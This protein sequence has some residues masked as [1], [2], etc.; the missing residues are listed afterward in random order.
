[1][2]PP[3]IKLFGWQGERVLTGYK[4]VG[5]YEGGVSGA[6]DVK[7]R[8]YTGTLGMVVAK[9]EKKNES[10]GTAERRFI[11]SN[12]HVLAN[13]NDAA[14]G[15]P[16]IHPGRYYEDRKKQSTIGKLYGFAEITH[17]C[18]KRHHPEK[19]YV[20]AA[21]AEITSE[22]MLQEI[23]AI[24]KP[25]G[26]MRKDKVAKALQGAPY[27]RLEVQ[28]YGA[29]TGRTYG[30]LA[31]MGWDGWVRYELDAGKRKFAWFED[32]MLIRPKAKDDP[33]GFC[34]PGDSGAIVMDMQNRI[35]GLLF[36]SNEDYS[37][38]NHIEDVRYAL[39]AF[40]FFQ[41]EVS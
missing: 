6:L 27:K 5:P 1:M 41:P 18:K 8:K 38:A 16:V 34:D 7:N 28:K 24:G 10:Q 4:P 12:N 11:L 32:Q 40:E 25:K 26:W 13:L 39:P 14:M 36:A 20:D 30:Y 22:T 9:P 21:L 23:T 35:I 17:Y 19:N 37:L 15:D 3:V 33:I 29:M 2:K 31:D